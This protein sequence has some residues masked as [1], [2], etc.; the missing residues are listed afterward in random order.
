MQFFSILATAALALLPSLTAA[1]E[2]NQAMVEI[3]SKD[4]E[5]FQYPVDFNSCTPVIRTEPECTGDKM[6]FGAGF[7]EFQREFI[8]ESVN[9]ERQQ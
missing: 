4:G 7:H 9:C 8:V 3:Y 1:Q 5:N 6:K 2:D